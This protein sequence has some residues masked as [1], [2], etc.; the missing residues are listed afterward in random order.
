[1]QTLRY[2]QTD[3]L[4]RSLDAYQKGVNRQLAVLATGLGKTAIASNLRRHHCFQKRVLFLVHMETLATQAGDAMA[5]WNPCLRV[6]VEMAGSYVDFD[7]FYPP[8]LI[9]ASVPTLGRKG[10][11][12]I[13]RFLPEEFDAIIQDEAHISMADSFKRVYDHFGLLKPNPSGPLFLGITAT[14]N[15]SDG[16]GLKE[17]FDAIIFDMG[18]QKGIEQGFLCDIRGIRVAGHADLAGVKVVAGEFQKDQLEKAV[19]TPK[20]NAIIV[21]EWYKHAYDRRTIAFTVDVQHALD[22]AEAFKAH[23]VSAK[24][25]WGDDKERNAKI[26]GH[27]GGEYPVICCAQLLGIGYDDPLV[28][29][30]ILSAPRKSFVRYAQEVGRGTRIADGKQDLL[31]IDVGDNASRH[32]LCSISTLLGLPKD[33]DLKGEKYST[34]KQKLD[35]IA[36]E[37]PAANVHDI[38]SLSELK[39]I[40]ENI[41]LF[42]VNYPPEVSRLSEL[43]WRKAGEGYALAVNRDLLTITKDLR[44]EYHISGNINGKMVDMT[45]QNLSGAFNLADSFIPRDVIGI[46]KRDVRWR[47]EEPTPKQLGMCRWLGITV[48]AGATKGAVS[49][50]IDAKMA[51]RSKPAAQTE[52]AYHAEF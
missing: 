3:C 10:S 7:G 9:V 28:N 36:T 37:F 24:A 1:M 43:A 39:S 38:K 40:A 8:H 44:D 34:A 42:Q 14:P 49:A 30:I 17:L 5:R 22:L 25:V 32:N 50:A 29:C 20:R 52:E 4:D 13:K 15:R 6:G 45:A 26:N 11:D 31:V 16:Q 21:K 23:G 33:L 2:Y 46:L 27:K 18:I 41:S 51:Q 48:P 35:R 19:N 47:T 12:R